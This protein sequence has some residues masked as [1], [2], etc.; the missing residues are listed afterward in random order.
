MKRIFAIFFL[1]FFSISIGQNIN[2]VSFDSSAEYTPGSGVSVHLNP[3]G[4]FDFVN[5]SDL[6]FNL[7]NSFI[8][9]LSGPGGD[10]EKLEVSIQEKIFSLPPETKLLVGHGPPTTVSHEMQSNPF[11]RPKSL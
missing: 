7:N 5:A 1:F 6:D 4:I 11:V 10:F 3:T 8:L 2:I 9:E